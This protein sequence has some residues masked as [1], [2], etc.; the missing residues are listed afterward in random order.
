[1]DL[2]GQVSKFVFPAKMA[3]LMGRGIGEPSQL[4]EIKYK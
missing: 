3:A 2:Q 1:M 4:P